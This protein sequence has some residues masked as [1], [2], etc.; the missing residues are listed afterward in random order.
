VLSPPLYRIGWISNP[1]PVSVSAVMDAQWAQLCALCVLI[2]VGS[3][4]LF[5]LGICVLV[6]TNPIFFLS[7]STV[8]VTG[9][10][11]W[12]A[13]V[14]LLF[15]I[16]FL[17]SCVL[18]LANTHIHSGLVNRMGRVVVTGSVY[19]LSVSVSLF[20]YD[21]TRCY[22]GGL[23]ILLSSPVKWVLFTRITLSL[24]LSLSDVS[25]EQ[26]MIYCVLCGGRGSRLTPCHVVCTL[27]FTHVFFSLYFSL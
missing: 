18:V 15:F 11:S 5:L 26:R 13:L 16:P 27:S 3:F 10:C 1:A 8:K 23:L 2:V 14:C 17:F 22:S 4:S 20:S 7:L 21:M 25:I 6:L 19:S 24:C 12:L 9:G